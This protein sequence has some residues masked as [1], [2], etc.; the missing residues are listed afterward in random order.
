MTSFYRRLGFLS[1]LH[2]TLSASR[3][4]D[5]C[6]NVGYPQF[7]KG[8]IQ[9][10]RA[11]EFD[12]F[13]VRLLLFRPSAMTFF[14][15][16]SLSLKVTMK[17]PVMKFTQPRLCPPNRFCENEESVFNLLLLTFYLQDNIARINA[18]VD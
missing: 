4:N 15:Y 8:Q 14:L 17:F 12:I 6:E 5:P 10:S 18:G 3:Y 13:E 9:T 11:H 7:S 2:C 1:T 16:L